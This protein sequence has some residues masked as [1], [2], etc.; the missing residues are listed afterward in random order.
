M[1]VVVA[2]PPRGTYTP[3]GASDFEYPAE[4]GGGGGGGGGAAECA[5]GTP[6]GEAASPSAATGGGFSMYTTFGFFGIFETM[7]R[8]LSSDSRTCLRID[9]ASESSFSLCW[10]CD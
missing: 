4:V 8:Q 5:G 2:I 10:T 3:P 7:R 6:A 9:R 1:T